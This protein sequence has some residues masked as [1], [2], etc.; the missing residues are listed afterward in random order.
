MAELLPD[1]D[2]VP[3]K[4]KLPE[5]RHEASESSCSLLD[6]EPEAPRLLDTSPESTALTQQNRSVRLSRW[7][8]LCQRVRSIIY[9]STIT[10]HQKSTP[11][12]NSTLEE[13]TDPSSYDGLKN[14]V[15][16]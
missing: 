12:P 16:A 11:F 6:F 13:Q 14:V 3:S 2:R 8:V 7:A 15:G 1:A 10:S 9:S 4:D 5:G